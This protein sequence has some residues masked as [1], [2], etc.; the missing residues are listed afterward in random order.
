MNKYPIVPLGEVCDFV[1]GDGLKE[2]DRKGGDVPVYGS[3][4]IVGWH[5]EAITK[6]ETL[7]VGRKGSIGEV[8]FSK[9]PCWAID[10]TY[11]IE[12]TKVPCDF[13]WLYYTLKALDLTRLSKLPPPKA[14]A[15]G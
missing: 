5:D 8:H 10:T 7:I 13:T 9:V 1:Y 15:L 12:K 3:N 4:G 11:F 2:I 6:G 14:V